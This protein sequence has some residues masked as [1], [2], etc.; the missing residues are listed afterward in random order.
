MTALSAISASLLDMH[1]LLAQA[2]ELRVSRIDDT[3]VITPVVVEDDDGQI[4]HAR[5]VGASALP[6]LEIS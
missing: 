3:T 2:K 5:T 1:D 6:S 4:R